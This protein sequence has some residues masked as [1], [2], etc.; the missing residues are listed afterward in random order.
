MLSLLDF[1]RATNDPTILSSWNSSI[2]H[3]QW[4][5]VNCSLKHPGRVNALSL[6]NLGLSGPISPSL[7]NLTFLKILDLSGNGFTG[8][9]PTLNH[10]HRLEQL[11]MIKNSLEGIIPD[12]LTNCSNL[13]YLD[14]SGNSLIGEIPL[15]I[16]RLYN[17]YFLG[18]SA[19]NLTGTITP[20]LKNISQLRGI[21][22]ADNELTGTIPDELGQL[23]NL[24]GLVIGGNRLSGG[25]PEILYK[26]NQSS[27]E[28]L[29]VS[30]NMLGKS[31]P[32]NF[33]DTLPSLRELILDNN[34]FEGHI[35]AS[36]GNISGICHPTISPVKFQV[37]V[38]GLG[39]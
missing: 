15:N 4:K 19:N 6:G 35:P 32:F 10:L 5:G 8:E 21:F 37:L 24:E 3:C 39:C 7:G 38:V 20:S 12:T 34:K 28:I 23:P 16:G 30:V 25:I 17:L 33:G 9:I 26:T 18:L 36:I 13:N 2:P 31:L 11:L 1:K 29:D 14:L 27:L 22:L